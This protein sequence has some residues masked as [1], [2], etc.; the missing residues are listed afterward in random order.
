MLIGDIYMLSVAIVTYSQRRAG[1]D[2]VQSN[3]FKLVY[4][5]STCQFQRPALRHCSCWAPLKLQLS[6]S[7]T[8]LADFITMHSAMSQ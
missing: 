8:N 6:Y 5:P 3:V 2:F 7:L 4:L 1:N